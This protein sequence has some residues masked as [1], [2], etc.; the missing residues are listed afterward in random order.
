MTEDD[1]RNYRLEAIEARQSDADKQISRLS[2]RHE[3]AAGRIAVLE[4]NAVMVKEQIAS[5]VSLDA[6]A[7][8][9]AIAF[10]LMGTTVLAVLGALLK[11]AL[12][13]R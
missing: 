10:G 2:E 3:Q 1:R 12:G 8:V 4:A 13:G 5:K 7:P 11:L 6:F 9:R